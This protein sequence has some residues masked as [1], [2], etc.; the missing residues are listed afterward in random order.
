MTNQIPKTLGLPAKFTQWQPDQEQNVDLVVQSPKKVFLLDA[1]TGTGKSLVGVA[2]YK[3]LEVMD[4]VLGRM[5]DDQYRYQCVYL[6]RTIQLQNQ[7]LGDFP[8]AVKMMGRANFPCAARAN[9]FPSFS[10]DDCPGSCGQRC[11]YLIHKAMAL[12]APLAVLND[13]YFLADT[14]GPGGFANRNMVVLDEIDSLESQLMSFI[15]FKVSEN[16][17]KKYGTPPP[18]LMESIPEW[19]RWARISGETITARVTQ[20]EDS[21]GDKPME[22]WTA[23]EIDLNKEVKRGKRFLEKMGVFIKEVNDTWILDLGQNRYGWEVTFKPVIVGPYCEEYL[24]RYGKRFLGMSGTIL[25][26]KILAEDLGIE[27][28]DY[29]YHRIDCRFPVQNR[30]IHFRPVANM[31][32]KTKAE[33][34]PKMAEEAARIIN[35][36]RGENVLVHAVSGDLRDYLKDVLPFNGVSPDRIMTHNT[37]DRANQIEAFKMARGKV[38]IS[39]SFDRG[40]DLPNDE[41]RCVIVCKV[42]FMKTTDKQVKARMAMPSGNRWY[43]LRAIQSIMQ[44]TGRGVRNDKDVCATYILDA[45]FRRVLTQTKP[46]IPAWWIAA[47][48]TENVD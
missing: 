37:Q 25:E 14:N 43:A 39:P 29:E 19:L 31:T 23:V 24:W 40:V 17:C 33:E 45:Q 13:S 22:A 34:Q 18:K 9:D 26:P 41:C 12:K 27:P 38:M 42:P 47:L 16:Q 4:R 21:L 1:P 48:R 36:Y 20:I 15:E 7:V 5:T 30:P 11:V 32:W 6:T 10:A 46:W 44:M 8:E 2:S 35:L 3:R 28:D